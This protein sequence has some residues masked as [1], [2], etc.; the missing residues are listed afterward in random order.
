MFQDIGQYQHELERSSVAFNQQEDLVRM[1][2]QRND[3]IERMI[4]QRRQHLTELEDELKIS[5]DSIINSKLK[6]LLSSFQLNIS[7]VL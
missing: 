2:T 6:Y 4:Q 1:L 7:Y 3:E 5:G